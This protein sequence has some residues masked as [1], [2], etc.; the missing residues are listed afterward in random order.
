MEQN[1]ELVGDGVKFFV[2]IKATV[3]TDKVA[4]LAERIKGKTFQRNTRSC[5]RT[6]V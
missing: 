4:E 1:R 6:P 5:R 3:M 2:K